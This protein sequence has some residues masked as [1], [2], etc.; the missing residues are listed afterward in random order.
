[1]QQVLKG[2][3]KN[4]DQE[5]VNKQQLTGLL[6]QLL[7]GLCSQQTQG[8]EPFDH[9]SARTSSACVGS[10][11]SCNAASRSSHHEE[12]HDLRNSRQA[13]QSP[14]PAAHD[15]R[16]SSKAAIVCVAP[17]ATANVGLRTASWDADRQARSSKEQH[18]QQQQQ[19]CQLHERG[20]SSSSDP[21]NGQQW[22]SS[23]GA[24]QPAAIQQ[25]RTGTAASSTQ[26][27]DDAA[28]VIAQLVI[29]DGHHGSTVTCNERL[30]SNSSQAKAAEAASSSLV[31][32]DSLGRTT[33]HISA[34]Q[35]DATRTAVQLGPGP[36]AAHAGYT[37]AA[38]VTQAESDDNDDADGCLT[39]EADFLAAED[40]DLNRATD[41]ELRLAKVSKCRCTCRQSPMPVIC[42]FTKASAIYAKQLQCN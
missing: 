16:A 38:D 4:L 17:D 42:A 32:A 31:H 26:H 35:G 6:A 2:F 11:N 13:Q 8:A 24:G 37:V 40:V 28:D 41:Y 15:L 27:L 7:L 33:N 39:L 10:S 22:H 1:M 20:S 5:S 18:K 34:Y 14:V 21:D 9:S 36:A 19:H 30:C 23:S 25:H 29:L 3:P 12:R